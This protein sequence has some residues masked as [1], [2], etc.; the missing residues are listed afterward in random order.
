MIQLRS[1]VQADTW[2]VISFTC[3]SLYFSGDRL[4]SFFS[5]FSVLLKVGRVPVSMSLQ[6]LSSISCYGVKY[7][8]D[9]AETSSHH[10]W[11]SA[12]SDTMERYTLLFSSH[13]PE[14]K[15]KQKTRRGDFPGSPV[16]MTS[17]FPCH[18]VQPKTNKTATKT[19]PLPVFIVFC[20][21]SNWLL[22]FIFNLFSSEHSIKLGW[23]MRTLPLHFQQRLFLFLD[24]LFLPFISHNEH[25]PREEKLVW[26]LNSTW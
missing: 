23:K 18:V 20:V 26:F 25:F 3:W 2:K 21:F 24:L 1:L 7:Q 15:K 5:V 6:S 4:I 22:M 9:G 19:N 16:V 11:L 12:D 13:F 10:R 17:Y 8:Y 14:L